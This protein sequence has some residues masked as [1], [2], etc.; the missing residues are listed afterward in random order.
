M[1]LSVGLFATLW[2]FGSLDYNAVYSVAPQVNETALT[3][4][5]LLLFGGAM[6]KSAQVPLHIWLADAMEGKFTI[7][8]FKSIT[9]NIVAIILVFACEMAFMF[10]DLNISFYTVNSWE[11]ANSLSCIPLLT[12]S[13]QTLHVITGS[14][15]GDGSI[16]RRHKVGKGI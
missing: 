4:I 2:V 8:Q 11:S 13:P 15:L 1:L 9:L 7:S 5:G 3:L 10:T 6:A 14:M 12:L 16:T